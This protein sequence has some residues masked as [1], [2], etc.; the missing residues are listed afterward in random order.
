MVARASFCLVSQPGCRCG[1]VTCRQRPSS[2][3][4]PNPS[5]SASSN[6]SVGI[7][8]SSGTKKA[9][10]KEPPKGAFLLPSVPQKW[11]AIFRSC[12]FFVNLRDLEVYFSARIQSDL[13]VSLC[14]F[15]TYFYIIFPLNEPSILFLSNARGLSTYKASVLT[16]VS[17]DCLSILR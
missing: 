1:S 14:D 5:S 10:P 12:G 11:S 8:S 17:L 7:S 9:P 6:S 13:G 16:T 3:K 2:H 15:Q 4:E